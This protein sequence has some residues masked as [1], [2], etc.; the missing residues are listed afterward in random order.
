MKMKTKRT[1][2]SSVRFVENTDLQYIQH[3][4]YYTIILFINKFFS[5]LSTNQKYK[6][7]TIRILFTITKKTLA[8][9]IYYIYMCA[10]YYN[11]INQ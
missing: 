5:H 4:K 7:L 10:L 8:I 11:E 9:T 1:E 6:T 3:I 2:L